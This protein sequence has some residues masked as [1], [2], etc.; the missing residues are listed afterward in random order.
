MYKVIKYFT[1]LQDN[2]YAYHEGDIFPR[3][4][5]SFDQSRYDELA[6]KDNKRKTP[7]IKLVKEKETPII[8]ET[9]EEK[10]DPVEKV[11]EKPKKTTKTSSTPKKA[12]NNGKNTK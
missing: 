8:T 3:E 2:K 12:K 1:D 4:G 11:A 5:I 10:S 7:L 6:G 9:T